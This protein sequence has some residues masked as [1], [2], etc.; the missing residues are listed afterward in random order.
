MIGGRFFTLSVRLN[1]YSERSWW[2]YRRL[3]QTMGPEPHGWLAQIYLGHRV[4]EL[5]YARE[6]GVATA[7]VRSVTGPYC[8]RLIV[9]R[10]TPGRRPLCMQP[11]GRSGPCDPSP[12]VRPPVM[13]DLRHPEGEIQDV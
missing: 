3:S 5:R 8:G 7:K 13:T 11:R 9:E 2:G 10:G 6:G 4:F 12:F 1:A